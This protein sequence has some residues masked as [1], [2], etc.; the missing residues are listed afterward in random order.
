MLQLQVAIIW[1]LEEFEAPF[2]AGEE[3]GS[4]SS[5]KLLPHNLSYDPIDAIIVPPRNDL[6]IGIKSEV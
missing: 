2:W 5:F 1:V 4:E 3:R 6:K